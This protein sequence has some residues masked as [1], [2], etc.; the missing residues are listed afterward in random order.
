M[1]SSRLTD[2][3]GRLLE[4]HSP[5]G[6]CDACLAVYFRISLA[7]AKAAALKLV[8]E[9]R[10]QRQDAICDMCYRTVLLTSATGRWK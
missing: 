8:G 5:F 3:I 9:P 1:A 4:N 7:E 10:F 2:E 6:R